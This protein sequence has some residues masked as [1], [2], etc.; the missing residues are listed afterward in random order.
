MWPKIL[1]SS[2]EHRTIHVYKPWHK[3]EVCQSI[4][5]CVPTLGSKTFVN[6]VE[7]SSA[8]HC[9]LVG[10]S[11][12]SASRENYNWNYP[13]LSSLWISKQSDDLT[14]QFKWK[15]IFNDGVMEQDG[16]LVVE[17]KFQNSFAFS[18][19]CSE[20]RISD[21][22]DL[23]LQLSYLKTTCSL[24]NII[25]F[26]KDFNVTRN[27]CKEDN[28]IVRRELHIHNRCRILFSIKNQK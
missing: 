15:R 4:L 13:Q 18:T 6:E 25:P 2:G 27:N 5:E 19:Q 8:L 20:K 7:R 14:L 11:K 17:M 12:L 23:Y 1:S 24:S 3:G 22:N 28:A 21:E 9:M 26:S 16:K 10:A